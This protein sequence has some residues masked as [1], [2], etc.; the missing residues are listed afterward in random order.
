MPKHFRTYIFLIFSLFVSNISKAQN[1][2][3]EWINYNQQY[4][5]LKI[6]QKGVYQMS[7]TDLKTAG[8]PTNIN[9]EKIQLFRRGQEQSI[10]IK[11]EEDK[12]L[13]ETDLIEFYAEGNDGALDSLLYS[14]T[15][16][17]PHKYYSLYSDTA[18]YFLTYRLDNQLGKRIKISQ[19]SNSQNLKPEPFNVEETLQLFT[20]SYAEGQP[21]P[22]GVGSHAGVLNSNYGYGRGWTG[23]VQNKNVFVNFDFNLRNFIKIDTQKPQLEVLFTG[24]SAGGHL[25][26]NWIGNGSNQRLLDTTISDNYFTKKI[27]KI[28]NFQ[29]ITNNTL[30]FST[31]S[32]GSQADQY[33]VSY[34]KLTYPQNFDMLG[35]SE[36]VFTLP[37]SSIQDRFIS[38]PN[39]PEGIQLYDISDKNNLQKIGFSK[40]GNAIESVISGQQILATNQFKKVSAIE[41]ISFR[42]I[43]NSKANYLIINHKSL[44]KYVKDY[45]TYRASAIGGKYDTLSVDVDFLYNLFTYGDKNPLAIKRFFSKMLRNGKPEFAFLIGYATNPQKSRKSLSDYQIDLVPT[46]GYPGGDVPFTMGL[47]GTEA[48]FSSLAIGRL[49]TDNP[50]TVLHYLNKVKEHEVNP[51][52]A[53]WRKTALKMSGGRSIGEL[54]SLR[55]YTEEFKAV[56]ENGLFGQKVDLLAKKTDNPVEFINVT[57]RVNQ[58]VGMIMMFGHS[59]PGQT[60]MDI[61]FCSNDLL[62][63][64]N[65][66]KY[67][68]VLINGCDAGDLFGVRTSFGTDWVNTPNRGAILFLAHSNLGY[69]FALKT[70]SDEIYNSQ[71]TDSLMSDKPFG[72]IIKESSNRH[73]KKNFGN[74]YALGN[75]QQFTLQGDPAVALFASQ[76]PD[77]EVNSTSIFLKNLDKNNVLNANADSLKVGIIVSN[78][79]RVSSK[80][81]SLSLKRMYANGAVDDFEKLTVNPINFQDTLYFNIRNDK[82]LSVGSNRFEIKL[83]PDNQ[84]LESRENN[85]TVVYEYNFPVASINVLSPREFSIVNQKEVVFTLQIPSIVNNSSVIIE[86]DSSKNYSS[87][88]KKTFTG[89]APP[90]LVWKTNL[91]DKDS[92]VYYVRAKHTTDKNWIESSFIYIK[93]GTEGFAQNSFSQLEKSTTDNQIILEGNNW[94]FPESSMKISA[95][96]YGWNSGVS[97]PYRSNY[98]LLNDK[99]LLG[100][101]VCYPW[102]N[103]NAVAFSRALRPYSVL[104]RLVCGY[105]PYSVNYLS[106][107]PSTTDIEDYF[108]TTPSGNHVM[109]WNSGYVDYG[110]LTSENLKRFAEIGVDTVKIKRLTPG[111][112]FFVIGRKGAKKANLEVFPNFDKNPDTEILSIDNFEVKD[113]FNAGTITSPLIGPA[114]EWGDISLKIQQ[115][116]PKN[117]SFAYDVIGVNTQG[118][119]TVLQKNIS[120]N[121]LKINTI[122]V[123]KYP[124]L[125]LKL[126]LKT[127]DFFGKAPQLKAWLVTYKGVPEGVVDVAHSSKFLDKQEYEDFTANVWFKNISTKNFKDSITV[128]QILSNR[129]LNKQVVKLFK[130][131]ALSAN[132][133]VKISIPV[134]T[135]GQIGDNLLSVFFNPQTQ[136]EQIYNNNSIDYNFNV[137]PDKIN[138]ILSVTFDGKQIQNNEIVSA[139]PEILISLKDENLFRIKT[140]TLGLE[141]SLKSCKK[142]TFKRIYFKDPVISWKANPIDNNFIIR[143]LPQITTNDTLT[144]Q[145]QGRDV[146]GNL[147]GTL[148][149]TIS[150][151]IIQKQEVKSFVVY[152][153]PFELFT[154]FSFIITGSEVPDEFKIEV[155]D[156]QGKTVKIIDQTKQNLRVGLNEFIWDGTDLSGDKLPVGVYFYRVT[157]KNKGTGLS[158]ESGKVI[159]L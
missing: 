89:T 108:T 128:R 151:R 20:S 110:K 102:Q 155:F 95:K 1:L 42:N 61:G 26:E 98:V 131:K 127:N 153:N 133:S 100:D 36:K 67:P 33:S 159:K 35:V 112:P 45:A 30:R 39:A 157:L 25:I 60:D 141:M 105:A 120:I 94:K 123:K 40:N 2:G 37:K 14:P 9:P 12:K 125:K 103:F 152:P 29:D 130:I 6:T 99:V 13:D 10:F 50:E 62:G 68:L 78:L 107:E 124:F 19:K 47:N 17:Q 31:R 85:N 64:K 72:T 86:L 49:A 65:K 3:N 101:G 74:I 16:S 43:S 126:T 63:Y 76:K 156:M 138:P 104:P 119:E 97:R 96:V 80:K 135:A 21:D 53:L 38:I 34:L 148:P 55:Q 113:Q 28:V 115:N 22:I 150:F 121:Q 87:S 117:Q 88:F 15:L 32:V 73:L 81:L 56:C 48:N 142:C 116:D 83:D 52:D 11:G 77:Y 136:P 84:I 4:F 154:K 82:N 46:L 44:S 41:P 66:G 91:L 144:L 122:D 75:A 18:S 57:E 58:G 146:A 109:I 139:K 137:I 54:T 118:E 90:L 93:N 149:Y 69:P 158:L 114:S 132:D 27:L 92:T 51:M 70:Y 23:D 106:S 134:Q 140:D 5:K 147:A 8:F 145:V 24:R 79:G 129:S 71:F 7:F 59:A 143:Y 111:T